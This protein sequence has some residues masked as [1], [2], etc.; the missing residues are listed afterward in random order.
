[1]DPKY[2]PP[3]KLNKIK[4]YFQTAYLL[5]GKDGKYNKQVN[6]TVC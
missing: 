1:M 5:E 6:H 4:I 3:P 2:L